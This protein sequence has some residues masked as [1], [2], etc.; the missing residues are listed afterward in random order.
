MSLSNPNDFGRLLGF[1]PEWY[2]LGIV[3][4][5]LLDRLRADWD[6]GDDPNT[7]HYRYRAFSDFVLVHQ[8]LSPALALALYELGSRDADPGMGGAM[9]VNIIYRPDCPESVLVAAAASGQRHLV[10]A[11][12]SRRIYLTRERGR[13]PTVSGMLFALFSIAGK[14]GKDS[15]MP[16]AGQVV[17]KSLQPMDTDTPECPQL[18]T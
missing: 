17:A 16:D 8:P 10:R 1:T 9:M 11:A 3:D 2:T 15:G 12:E 6:K 14:V 18:F 5:A 4:D 7:E 13:G